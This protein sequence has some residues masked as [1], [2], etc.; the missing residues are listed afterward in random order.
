MIFLGRKIILMATFSFFQKPYACQVSGCGKRY[1]DP[2]SLRKHLK[3][4][5]ENSST[6]S[7]LLSSDKVSNNMTVGAIGH[8]LNST[9]PHRGGQDACIFDVE[10]NHSSYKL[11]KTYVKEENTPNDTCQLNRISLNCDGYQQEYVPIESVRHLLINDVIN[12][13][14]GNDYIQSIQLLVIYIS[15]IDIFEKENLEMR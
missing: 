12:E 11:S 10:T 8:E 7:S 3:N 1:T 6:L 15:P 4:H 5:T 9:I 2:S 13:N 14:T